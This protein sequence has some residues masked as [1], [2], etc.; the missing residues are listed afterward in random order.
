MNA[1]MRTGG[2]GGARTEVAGARRQSA[3]EARTRQQ[4]LPPER[5]LR[6][7]DVLAQQRDDPGVA[8]REVRDVQRGDGERGARAL[9]CDAR[10][11][12]GV[13]QR[14]GLLR[15]GRAPAARPRHKM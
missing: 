7:A 1:S 4:K 14:R 11:D 3:D 15:I 9:R 8:R 5:H 12:C 10:A 13:R 6:A 2:P